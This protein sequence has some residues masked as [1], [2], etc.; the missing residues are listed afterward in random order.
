MK[1][2]QKRHM[3]DAKLNPSEKKTSLRNRHLRKDLEI[4]RKGK[5]GFSKLLKL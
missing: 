4:D 1:K 2:S 5:E 3:E